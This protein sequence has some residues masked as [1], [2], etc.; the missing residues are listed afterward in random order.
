MPTHSADQ[1]TFIYDMGVNMVGVPQI[2]IPAGYLQKGDVVILRYAEQLYPGF[3][4]DEKYYV[5]TYGSKGKNMGLLLTRSRSPL[6]LR[7]TSTWRRA[8]AK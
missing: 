2:T 8:V 1:H 3:K 5:D 6:T 4:G 7:A